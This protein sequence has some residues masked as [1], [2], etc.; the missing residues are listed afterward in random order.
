MKASSL[1]RIALAAALVTV[2]SWISIPFT[3]PF[4]LQTF[5]VFLTLTVLGGTEGTVAVAV[6]IALGAVG[7]PVFSGFNSGIGALL[8]PT[9]GYIFGFLIMGGLKIVFDRL[10]KRP[11]LDPVCLAAGLALCYIAGTVWFVL[12][13]KGR[14][15]PYSFGAAL[16]TC[17]VPYIL[18]DALKL[19]LALFVGSR[20]N[21]ALSGRKAARKDAQGAE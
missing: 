17:V 7:A 13:M 10:I 2:C 4:T 20:I 21:R 3:V 14:G 1:V 12:V 9:G 16:M 6:Y 5:A 18:P 19:A 11:K 8:G 15:N